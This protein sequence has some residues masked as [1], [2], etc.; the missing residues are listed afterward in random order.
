LFTSDIDAL[1]LE[2]SNGLKQIKALRKKHDDI[3]TTLFSM[4]DKDIKQN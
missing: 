2:I 4:N 3:E 1:K